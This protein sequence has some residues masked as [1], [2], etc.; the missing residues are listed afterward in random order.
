MT[1]AKKRP[2]VKRK[3]IKKNPVVAKKPLTKE[4]ISRVGYIKAVYHAP[5]EM[6]KL[7]KRH[8][9]LWKLLGA[10]R[11]TAKTTEKNLLAKL[12]KEPTK[13]SLLKKKPVRRIV[14]NPVRELDMSA[15]ERKRVLA[16][17]DR[18]IGGRGGKIRK[19]AELYANFTGHDK[20]NVRKMHVPDQPQVVVEIGKI[21][22][23]GYTTVRDGKTER[24][25]HDF[26]SSARPQFAVSI[27]GKQIFLLGGAF[28]FG[29]RGIVDER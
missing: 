26:K 15:Q 13:A 29:D 22:F 7:Y 8:G 27:D 11:G 17:V 24:Y 18:Q 12:P 19:A 9:N 14:K 21:D 6:W 5:I 4:F 25:K 3:A 20:I 1:I 2:A 23:I 28:I 16:E 10:V